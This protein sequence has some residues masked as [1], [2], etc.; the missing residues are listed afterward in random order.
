MKN[1]VSLFYDEYPSDLLQPDDKNNI[2]IGSLIYHKRVDEN[3]TFTNKNTF[4]KYLT[5]PDLQSF[6]VCIEKTDILRE[7][8]KYKLVH[9]EGN[10]TKSLYNTRNFLWCSMLSL[11]F[12]MLYTSFFKNPPDFSIFYDPKSL[13]K[14]LKQECINYFQ[15]EFINHIRKM[16]NQNIPSANIQI[17]E[18]KKEMIGIRIADKKVR[19]YYD[20]YLNLQKNNRDVKNITENIEAILINLKE[21]G[22]LSN[23]YED[24]QNSL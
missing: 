21:K 8:L 5:D 14:D 4:D 17:K 15:E 11:C 19:N 23:S 3:I 20:S 1:K 24:F 22:N 9:Y 12:H 13:N 16:T 6:A 10:T 2:F 7:F 18:G